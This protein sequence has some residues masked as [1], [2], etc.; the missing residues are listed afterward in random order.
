MSD[1]RK[2]L[3]TEHEQ[4]HDPNCRSASCDER[5]F[6]RP[7]NASV[8]RLLEEAGKR[9]T[10]G[11]SDGLSDAIEALQQ[12]IWT[13]YPEQWPNGKHFVHMEWE[14]LPD[15]SVKPLLMESGHIEDRK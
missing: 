3:V 8:Y 5:Y 13:V 2:A 1:T 14:N 4:G 12:M 15:G 10:P 7:W 11:A 6:A 9:V